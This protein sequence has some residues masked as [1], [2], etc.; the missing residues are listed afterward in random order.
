MIQLRSMLGRGSG[1]RWLAALAAF[2][3]LGLS[4]TAQAAPVQFAGYS[5]Q[6]SNFPI[7]FDNS[8]G[9]IAGTAI[10]VTFTFTN[11]VMGVDSSLY[12]GVDATL[13]ISIT[14]ASPVQIIPGGYLF[15][16][17]SSAT[18][19]LTSVNAIGSHAAGSN[20]LTVNIDSVGGILTQSGSTTPNYSGQSDT[21][22]TDIQYT[23]AFANFA[24]TY[25]AAFNIGFLTRVGLVKRGDYFGSA[26]GS[27][28]G[29]NNQAS[30]GG[31]FSAEPP[32]A[33]PEPT[34]VALVALGLIGAP[35][36]LRRR[37]RATTA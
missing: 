1:T 31:Q 34:S 18:I 22:E 8:N 3:M 24:S 35:V 26:V 25:K 9:N 23:S 14:G 11:A 17:F 19:T 33:V 15:G 5:Q 28:L 27:G 7:T 30:S 12:S 4:S 2:A 29:G 10:P 16:P 32:P 36:V 21:G 20:L 13:S 6:T 37:R